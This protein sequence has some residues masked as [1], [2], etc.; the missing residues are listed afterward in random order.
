MPIVA[1]VSPSAGNPNSSYALDVSASNPLPVT[2]TSGGTDQDV[3]IAQVAGT[4]TVTGG[5][6]GTLG[7]G[8]AAAA[9]TALASA[10]NPVLIALSDGTNSRIAVS[11]TGATGTGVQRNILTNDYLSTATIVQIQNRPQVTLSLDT[12]AYGSGDVIADTQVI[13]DA[14]RVVGGTGTLQSLHVYDQ[15]DQKA[16]FT[17]YILR[18]NVSMGTENSPPSI[19]DVN[20]LEI[21]GRV[22]IA[23][24]DYQDLG[25]VSVAQGIFSPFVLKS[26]DASRDLYVAVVNGTGTPTYMASG[27]KI[28]FG[29][30]LD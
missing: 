29:I 30:T 26:A 10:G 2:L 3:N 23:V 15:D 25:G 9:G 19:S 7:V 14:L 4:N 13:T 20:A 5:V 17:V 16:A 12:S 18:S 1:F 24:G 27:I 8:G 22:S 28:Q 11:G 21:L 6:A